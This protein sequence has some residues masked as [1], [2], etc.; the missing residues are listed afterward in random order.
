[1]V[2]INRLFIQ[3]K[4]G[5]VPDLGVL[6]ITSPFSEPKEEACEEEEEN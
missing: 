2:E 3:E 4:E 6:V 1:M 5:L